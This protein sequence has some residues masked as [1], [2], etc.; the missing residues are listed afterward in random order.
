MTMAITA[1]SNS[2]APPWIVNSGTGQI[3]QLDERATQVGG[4]DERDA[5]SPPTRAGLFVYET[6]PPGLQMLQGR[7][8]RA[9][10]ERDVMHAFSVLLQET[11]HRGFR[12]ERHEQLN[13]R[14]TYRDHRL[15][16][17][18]GLDHLAIQ[19]LHPVA[20][21]VAGDGGVEIVDRDGDVIEIEELHDWYLVPSTW[22]LG[23][24]HRTAWRVSNYLVP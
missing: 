16:D 4:M 6:R 7:V 20:V 12:A 3:H 18:L 9:H 10:G 17:T 22:Y 1:A 23:S 8:D 2:E 5:A 15:L 14:A 11:P 19:R 21:G 24:D 13:E